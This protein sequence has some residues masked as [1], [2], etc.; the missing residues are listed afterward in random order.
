MIDFAF[1]AHFYQNIKANDLLRRPRPPHS[2]STKDYLARM[3]KQAST[4]CA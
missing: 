3:R 4:L 2:M 1:S